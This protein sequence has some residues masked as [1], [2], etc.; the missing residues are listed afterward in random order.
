MDKKR[1]L[2]A[3]S[4]F[5]PSVGGLETS[6]GQLGSELVADGYDVTVL[7]LAFPA[8]SADVRQGVRIVSV[9][10]AQLQGAIRAAVASGEYDACLLIQ[11]P[12]GTIPWS[13]EGLARPARTRVL[14][15]PIINED[16]YARWK[17]NAE[18]RQRLAAILKSAD[19]AL[20][21]TK[22]G[23]DQR[24][25]LEAGVEP[26]YLPNAS[27]QLAPAGDF[28]AQFGIPAERF[29]I[30]HVAN[31]YWVKNHV[32]LIDAL[33]GMPADWQLVMIGNP[34]GA[35]DCVEAV[36]AKLASRP[37]VRFIPGLPPEWIAAAMQAADVVVL[38]SHGEGSPITLLEAMS[39]R[40]PW[41][42]TPTCGAANDHLGG[43]ICPLSEFKARLHQLAAQPELR[44]ALGELS[45][46][47]WQQ[48]YAWPVVLQGWKDLIE[49]GRLQRSFAPSAQLLERQQQLRQTLDEAAPA[50]PLPPMN[51]ATTPLV[52]VVVIIYN[53]AKYLQKTL[54]SVEA[55]A[56]DGALE[57]ILHDDCSSDNSAEICR[58]FAARSRHTVKLI[59]QAQNK[60]G[61]QIG[62]WPEIYSQC[63]GE[64]IAI[65]DGDDFWLHPHKLAQQ[66]QGLALLP[67][68]DLTFHKAARIHWQSEAVT[69]Y[70]G[71]YG[72]EPR[73]FP[74]TAVIEGDGGFIPTPSIMFRRALVQRMPPWYFDHLPAGDYVLQ[75]FGALRGGA[76]YLPMSAAAYREGD[77]TSWSQQT[78]AD[79]EKV[80]RFDRTFIELLFQL[81]GSLPPQYGPNVDK[82][83]LG[84]FLLYCQRC[85]VHDKL[86]D[87]APMT[88]LIERGRGHAPA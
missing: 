15:Q 71:D 77:P 36:Q 18:F 47:H 40:K 17:D 1:I 68:V 10:M 38:A 11:D 9:A 50:A 32:G 51:T 60:V 4:H 28:R 75:V 73:L 63:S 30:L 20:T 2:I 59:L 54:D 74:V 76:L 37:D 13:I 23:P 81:R 21:M 39:Q 34:T 70:L 12:L 86:G 65:C 88:A 80:N 83:M 66:C 53:H 49:T 16:G 79:V 55:Q 78:T 69:G 64:Y 61:R 22:S 46:A 72:E 35:S 5:W 85:F 43:L 42:A 84:R 87:V 3:C 62:I 29:L 24:F 44:R 58:Q 33:A 26:V 56:I 27:A 14:V 57:I 7:T 82:L 41:L 52:S 31:L 8:R 19:A 6:M 48:C 45:Y 25:M 67:D